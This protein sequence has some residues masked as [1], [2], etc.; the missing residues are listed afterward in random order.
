[1]ETVRGFIF[2]GSKVTADGDCS[3]EIKRCWFFSYDQS[4][5]AAAA[6]KSPQSCPT[7]CDP[8]NYT[9]H[10]ILQARILE[11]VAFPFFRGTSRPRDRTQVSRIVGSCFTVWATREAHAPFYF[12]TKG[13]KAP[14]RYQ[15][16]AL[17]VGN[18]TIPECMKSLPWPDPTPSRSMSFY[19]GDYYSQAFL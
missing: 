3:H 18:T 11:W 17:C 19:S 8:M 2:C 12:I 1:M 14:W 7:L 9:V 16:S 13:F 10:G 5:A 15:G 4:A 6:A